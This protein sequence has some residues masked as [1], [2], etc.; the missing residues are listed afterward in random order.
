MEEPP[1]V[2]LLPLLVRRNE[3]DKPLAKPLAAIA[4]DPTHCI[5][6]NLLREVE[7][8]LPFLKIPTISI[9]TNLVEVVDPRTNSRSAVKIQETTS[10]LRNLARASFRNAL[11]TR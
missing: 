7:L 5:K 3:V 2:P 6:Q 10:L 4:N 11:S 1:N 9:S 8:S